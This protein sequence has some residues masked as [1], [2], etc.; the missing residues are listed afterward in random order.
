MAYAITNKLTPEEVAAGLRKVVHRSIIWLHF[1]DCI[2]CTKSLLQTSHPEF[3]DL[4]LN[5]IS[6]EYH[7]IP[8]A[9]SGLQARQALDEAVQTR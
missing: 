7:E 9:G 5:V 1:Q 8:M 2:G 6:L 3:G 4:I